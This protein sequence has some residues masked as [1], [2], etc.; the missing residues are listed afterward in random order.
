MTEID[1]DAIRARAERA[2]D[3]LTKRFYAEEWLRPVRASAR[4]VPLLLDEL[5]EAN[6]AADAYL[7]DLEAAITELDGGP[8]VTVEER[9]RLAAEVES[10]GPVVEAAKALIAAEP[11]NF[12][13]KPGI[14]KFLEALGRMHEAL[15]HLTE[16]MDGN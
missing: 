13:H 14:G 11:K 4:D 15:D 16:A 6:A 2:A 3:Q 8:C 5:A 7:A 9:D 1:L 10:T 12:V